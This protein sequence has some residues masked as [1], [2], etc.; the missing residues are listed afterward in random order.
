MSDCPRAPLL[1]LCLGLGC[2][3]YSLKGEEEP[4]P[5]PEDTGE[6]F[7]P[8]AGL[9]DIAA[10]PSAIDLGTR[11][12][13]AP[14]PVDTV[15]TV[16]NEGDAALTLSEATVEGEG[17][18]LG[19]FTLPVTLLPGETTPFTVTGGEGPGLF[20]LRSD[21]PD[22]PT[23]EIPLASEGDAPPTAEIV[24]PLDGSVLPVSAVTT[25]LGQLSD[26][27][28]AELLELSW[29]SDVDGLLSTDLA[30][31]DGSSAYLWDSAARSAGTHSVTLTV[32]DACGQS[33][34]DT[35]TF[36][37]DEGYSADSLD[38]TTWHFEGS[39]LYDSTNGW[40]EI[41][42]PLNT[43]SGTAFQTAA[44]VPADNVVVD[45]SFYVS[46][47][48]GADGFSL[49]ALDTTR[50][51]SFVG[52]SGGGIGYAGLPGWS[53]EVDTWYNPELGDPTPDDHVS[54]LFDGYPY[55]VYAWATLPEMEDGAWHTMQVSVIAPHV[56]VVID[57]VTY[58]DQDIA[59]TYA[60]PAYVGF[61]AATGGATNYHLI[62]ALEVT[63]YV[64]E[65][66]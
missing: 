59:G 55:T 60:F 31:P 43:Q 45:F 52:D 54:F 2:S 21:D 34:S 23:L 27:G 42:K 1:L 32:T 11:C 29:S 47:G 7:V 3:D 6:P 38:L 15:V 8:D 51:T 30:A 53:I 66:D 13:V 65:G 39:A 4:S 48:S 16:A 14:E 41:T 61:T 58:I 10:D 22:E 25:M 33:A 20:T 28:G 49:T 18:T 37:Q 24:D 50:M 5:T 62:D 46:G 57:G 64:C 26:D 12:G 40:V 63:R 17:W 35:V 44:T 56:T 19:A 9:P 36:C